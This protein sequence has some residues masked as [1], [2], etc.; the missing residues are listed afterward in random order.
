MTGLLRLVGLLILAVFAITIIRTVVGIVAK[1][2]TGGAAQTPARGAG[3]GRPPKVQTG[4]RLRR[5]PVCGTLT[6][7]DLAIRR[8]RG[9]D[10]E[11]FCSSECAERIDA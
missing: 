6:P 10:E 1:M 9:G 2:F 3:P 11:F 8:A 4:G 7:E 5:C